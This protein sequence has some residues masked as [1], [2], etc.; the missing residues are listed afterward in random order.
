M[1]EMVDWKMNEKASS[2]AGVMGR[3]PGDRCGGGR[4]VGRAG[5]ERGW[6]PLSGHPARGHAL[7]G[8]TLTRGEGGVEGLVEG[9]APDQ[10]VEEHKD[11][12]HA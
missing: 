10:Q 3:N 9:H 5:L 11:H 12:L 6:P 1:L 2:T 7:D 4:W 8:H